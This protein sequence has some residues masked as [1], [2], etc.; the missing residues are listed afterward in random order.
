MVARL[1]GV[2]EAGSSN[3][4]TQTKDLVKNT[5]R[6]TLCFLLLFCFG[7]RGNFLP[8]VTRLRTLSLKNTNV[9]MSEQSLFRRPA[10]YKSSHSDQRFNKKHRAFCF[11]FF[12]TL[13]RKRKREL[14]PG[15]DA[16]ADFKFQKN[17]KHHHMSEQSLFRRSAPYKSSH[18]DQ[19]F[20]KKHRAFCFVFFITL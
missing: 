7:E 17:V 2:Q 20:N 9:H 8:E 5:G 14:P 6:R 11:V 18:S 13:S 16:I 19:R 3:L 4:L 15:S 1:N 10:P 12:I